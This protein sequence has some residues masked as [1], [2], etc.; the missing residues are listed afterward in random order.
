MSIYRNA[1]IKRLWFMVI[2]VIACSNAGYALSFDL[3]TIAS[4]GRFLNFCV[5]A[6][7][8]TD[9]FFNEIDTAYVCPTGYRWNLK[10]RA[11]SW[12]DFNGFY[13]DGNHQMGML[14]PF[15]TSIGTDVQFMA[16]SIGYDINV[17]KIFGGSGK[18]R[19]KSRFSFEFSS[20]LLSGRYYSIKNDDGMNIKY[21]D[22][23]L[24]DEIPFPGVK[25][26]TWGIDL[27]YYFN[28]HRYSNQ[29]A[30]SFGK[31]QK[32]SQGSFMVGVTYQSQKLHFDF[33]KL[34]KDMQDWLPEKW[35][36]RDYNSDGYN[37]GL[38]GGYGHNWVVRKKVTFGVM[39]LVI[40]SLHYGLLNSE[41][42]GYS[43][44]M[45]YRLNA[46][47]V[48]NHNRWFIGAVARGD[49]GFIYSE[50]TLANGLFSLETKIGWRF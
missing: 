40:P 34:P 3:D 28:H 5:S 7:R 10:F 8:F 42:K 38:S 32:R 13:F 4:K 36:G 19:S 39:G 20:A 9:K 15:C 26:S 22:K 12:T 25:S 11:C 6:Y 27:T 2:I 48:W 35:K 47:A 50:S 49:V 33:S 18:D 31:I 1:M 14:S 43:F 45:N 16:V 44:R 23:K 30:F 46:Y 41:D 37:I 29:A 17:N 21:I 24:I